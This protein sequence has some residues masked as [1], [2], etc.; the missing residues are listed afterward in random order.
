MPGM[1]GGE[2]LKALRESK[3][4]PN[5]KKPCIVLTANAVAGAKDK[6]ISDGFSDYLS[7]PIIAEELERT[8]L[9]YLP[10]DKVIITREAVEKSRAAVENKESAASMDQLRNYIGEDDKLYDAVSRMIQR[11]KKN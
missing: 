6:Y 2:M 5:C 3:D 4:N 7:K 11:T 10:N 8:L 1:G 9:M